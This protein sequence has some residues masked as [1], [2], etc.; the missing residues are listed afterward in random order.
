MEAPWQN[1]T[2]SKS[3]K[4]KNQTEANLVPGKKTS[5]I[6]KLSKYLYQVVS[7]DP[8]QISIMVQIVIQTYISMLHLHFRAAGVVCDARPFQRLRCMLL[9]AI[10]PWRL[11]HHH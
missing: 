5:T 4:I 3:K 2:G 7:D 9:E 6:K 8:V 11:G 1:Q 10:L